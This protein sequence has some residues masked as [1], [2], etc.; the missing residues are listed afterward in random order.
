MV[1]S[2]MVSSGGAEFGE[3]AAAADGLEL[4]GVAD[5]RQ[6]P[7]V[8]V[9]ETCQL[10]EVSGVEHAGF[11]DDDGGAGGELPG[12]VGWPVG[13]LPFVEEFGDGVGPQAGLGL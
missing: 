13:V 11:V 12:G 9:G 4:V 3:H 6:P 2:S 5:Q 8:L 1:S 7:P 10:V